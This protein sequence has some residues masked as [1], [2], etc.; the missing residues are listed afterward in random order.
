MNDNISSSDLYYLL[1]GYVV[2]IGIWAL[3]KS[4]VAACHQ[5]GWI[6]T[7][8]GGMYPLIIIGLSVY[9][10]NKHPNESI[11]TLSVKYYGK[12]LGQFFN[13]LFFTF[14]FLIGIFI[15][16]GFSN[17]LIVYGVHFLPP[18]KV[19]GI[20]LIL[21]GLAAYKGIHLLGKINKLIFYIFIL[22]ILITIPAFWKGTYLNL[23]PMFNSSISSIIYGSIDTFYSYAAF[24]AILLIHPYVYDK[25]N[26]RFK[27]F[28]AVFTV[29]LIYCYT[30]VVTLYYS[31][32]DIVTKNIWP[33]VI[34]SESTK[35]SVINNFRFIF[36]STWILIALRSVSNY[37][38]ACSEIL[39][40]LFKK[41]KK[42]Y[43]YIAVYFLFL[44]F[45]M[46]LTDESLRR[47]VIGLVS[48]YY[49]IFNFIFILS[50]AIFTF[51]KKGDK[52]EKK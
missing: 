1:L 33:F 41:V 40:S 15:L 12:Y 35:F 42:E 6:P 38:F 47:Y 31:G 28:L 51:F 5:D 27:S 39:Q 25:A 43:V 32:P 4:Q 14:F 45:T 48:L 22:L 34:V 29:I 49:V 11:L 19:I 18:I 46:T 20:G 13:I 23:Q 37:H 26:I 50:I 2:V 30:V 16:S 36:S 24:E 9:I 44:F 3:P 8:L 21:T 52:N 7:L 17:V 10:I